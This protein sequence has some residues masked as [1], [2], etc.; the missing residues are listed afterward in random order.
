MPDVACEIRPLSACSFD[1]ALRAW[2]EGFQGYFVDMTLSLDK[3]L[4]RLHSESLSPEH[5]LLAFCEGRP[6]GI[7]LNGIRSSGDRKVAWN[8]GT[9]VGPEFR[10]QG[11]GKALMRATLDLYKRN[12]VDMATLEAISQN[13][14]AIALYKKFR[15]G[16]SDRL[17]FL[18]HEG[19]CRSFTR[20]SNE[21]YS[22][23]HVAPALTARL[24][25]YD[26]DAAWQAQW[27]SL[28]V[29]NGEAVIVKDVS[30]TD[31]GY[32]LYKRKFDEAGQVSNIA[33]YQ[34]VPRSGVLDAEGIDRVALEHVYG[35]A[36][37]ECRRTTY[38]LRAG[39]N[40]VLNI[41]KDAEFK[42][43]IEQVHMKVSMTDV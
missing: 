33:L 38:N 41:L 15:Y 31:V 18:E 7:L 32:A 2:N 35:P 22:V 36:Q 11:V 6:A 17:V 16:I 27:Q 20:A 43:F 12:S 21:S 26:A 1:E 3:F 23:R 30:G 39:D 34:C 42:L 28:A 8:G 9:G 37:N 19:H 13:D 40:L 10:G 4:S 24:D 25:F 29:T 5:S 14:S